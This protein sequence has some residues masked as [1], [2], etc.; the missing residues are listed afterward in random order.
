MIRH[1]FFQLDEEER[2][3]GGF[4]YRVQC[5]CGQWLPPAGEKAARSREETHELLVEHM[6]REKR[7]EA[8]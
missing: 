3:L 1:D 5:M 8:A 4:N 2:F 7:E 6:A